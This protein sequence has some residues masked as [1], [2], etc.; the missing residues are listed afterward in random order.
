MKEYQRFL[1]P[2]FTAFDPL[3]LEK[4]TEKIVTRKAGK[5]WKESMLA[6]IQH[7]CMEELLL[8]MLQAVACAVFTAGPIG[9]AIIPKSLESSIL[10]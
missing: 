9:L 5:D 1:R 10:Q 6:F 2:G 4:E 7:Q 3:E 8:D